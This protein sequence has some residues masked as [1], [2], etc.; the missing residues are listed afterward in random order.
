MEK[1]EIISIN[2][3]KEIFKVPKKI[4][5]RFPESALGSMFSG[6]WENKY[7]KD[8]NVIIKNR[9]TQSFKLMIYLLANE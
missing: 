2:L 1:D 9:D 8:G 4:L 3:G 5:T 7:D 6:R